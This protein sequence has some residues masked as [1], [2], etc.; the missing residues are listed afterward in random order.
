[1]KQA[2]IPL[3]NAVPVFKPKGPA[4]ITG[5]LICVESLKVGQC[6]L[7]RFAE[8]AASSVCWNVRFQIFQIVTLDIELTV[9]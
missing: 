9:S 7:R 2:G 5:L 8:N 3:K 4:L 1:M 6:G